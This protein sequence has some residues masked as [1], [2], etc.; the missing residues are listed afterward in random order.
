MKEIGVYIHI[1]FCKKKCFYCDFCSYENLSNYYEEYIN[2]VIKE[3]KNFDINN[4]EVLVK[5]IYIG[6]GTPSIIKESLIENVFIELN[7]KFKIDENVEF[8]IEI[9]P[10]TVNKEKLIKYKNIGI[11]RLSIGLQS[12]ND[13]LLKII[14]RIHNYEEF[15]NC[16]TWA[17]SVGFS[18][19][20][21]DLMIGLPTQTLKDVENSLKDIINKNLEHIS[22]YSLILEDDTKLKR[23]VDN[24]TLELPD[25]DMERDMYWTVKNMLEKNGYEQYEISNFSKKTYESKHNTDCWKQ[26]EYIGFGAAAH[27][28]FNSVRYSNICDIKE[29]INNIKNNQF[30]KNIEVQELQNDEDKMNEYMILGLRMINGVNVKRFFER[31][32]KNPK[33]KYQEEIKKLEKQNLII[34]DNECIK[35]TK[36]GIDFANVVWSEFI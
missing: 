21:V 4:E 26:K 19:I 14:G 12:T 10:G 2:S 23:L 15:E 32:G 22:V 17:R 35:L 7:N 20:N 18:N 8:T 25:E 11:N 29:F 34:S 36:K 28:Y 5:T 13:N 3:I 16:Y 27:S 30:K 9:N 24:K 6:G 1:P 31:F 33:V